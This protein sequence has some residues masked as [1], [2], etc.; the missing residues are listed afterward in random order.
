[1]ITAMLSARARVDGGWARVRQIDYSR[2]KGAKLKVGEISDGWQQGW[3]G[4][5]VTLLTRPDHRGK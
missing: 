3:A 5:A 2:I 4:G 1:M